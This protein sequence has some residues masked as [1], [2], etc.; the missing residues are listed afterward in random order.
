MLTEEELTREMLTKAT[1]NGVAS[2]RAGIRKIMV[3][4]AKRCML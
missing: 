1:N 2:I 4:K 3:P